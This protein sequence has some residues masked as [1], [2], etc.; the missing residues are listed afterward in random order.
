MVYPPPFEIIRKRVCKP[1]ILVYCTLFFLPS[2]FILPSPLY[3]FY[4]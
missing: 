3:F 4:S 2:P 1:F